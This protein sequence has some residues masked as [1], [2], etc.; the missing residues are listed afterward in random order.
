MEPWDIALP[1]KKLLLIYG[2]A[3]AAAFAALIVQIT[4][5]DCMSVPVK[6]QNIGDQNE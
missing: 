6:K 1:I 3:V 4:L 5:L 2:A